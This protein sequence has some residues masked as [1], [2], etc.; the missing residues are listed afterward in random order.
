MTRILPAIRSAKAA[1]SAIVLGVVALLAIHITLAATSIRH[2][3]NT[4]DEIAH[5]TA[6]YT[7]WAFADYRFQ[8]EN[9]NLPARWIGLGMQGMD[10]KFPDR[11]TPAWHT[12]NVWE[13]GPQFLFAQGND[14]AAL[15]FRSRMMILAISCLLALVVFGAARHWFGTPGGFVS[16]FLYALGPTIIAN[17]QLATSDMM[18][19]ATMT[20]AMLIGWTMM[21]RLTWWTLLGGGVALGA[22]MLSKFSGPILLPM[23]LLMLGLR[24]LR[25]APLIVRLQ[26]LWRGRLR[27]RWRQ[28]GILLAAMLVQGALVILM[29]WAIFGFRYAA[30]AHP[31][32]QDRFF[33]VWPPMIQAIGFPG[34]VIQL[35]KDHHLLPEAFLYGLTFVLRFAAERRSFLNGDWSLTGW[36]Y[37]F[38]YAFL[39][40]TALS[41]LVVM[42]LAAIAWPLARARRLLYK[43]APCWIFIL[44]FMLLLMTSHLNIGVRHMLP[45]YPMLFILAGA[46]GGW[47]IGRQRA[48]R[49]AMTVALAGLAVESAMIWP[50]YLAFFNPLAG[51]PTQGYRHL[52]DSSLDWGQD[53]PALH[54][55]LADNGLTAGEHAPVYLSYFGTASPSFYGIQAWRLDSDHPTDSAPQTLDRPLTPGYY[56]ISA[57]MLEGVYTAYWGPWCRPYE[58]AYIKLA[59]FFSN[60]IQARQHADT[61]AA[62]I[63]QVGGK[64]NLGR[65]LF[66]HD[67][68][69]FAR[70]CA[71][72][73]Q[74]E[75]DAM[76]GYSILIYQVSPEELKQALFGPPAE[77]ADQ[78]L[79]PLFN[80]PH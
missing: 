31:S 52:V 27:G 56:C 24:L 73:R 53:L 35:A 78:S 39:V 12:S 43:T 69:R 7:D 2:K 47:L 18:T 33:A 38:P 13:I 80:R 51:G 64:E 22:V 65:L 48:L 9:G 46:A 67:R 17:A 72:L 74:R 55:W 71:L 63:Q 68:L 60:Y 8:P 5:I 49:W 42:G 32:D 75:P 54:D 21:H 61:L 15:L 34:A 6:G 62:F 45:V 28:A 16:L 11:T 70:L 59:Q 77:L 19:A 23:F 44:V 40:K 1:R 10:L 41:S 4:Y 66:Q 50:D 58:E 29:I 30:F 14:T 26:P 3:S 79:M 57:S 76:V 37:F 20:I 25:R 36:W